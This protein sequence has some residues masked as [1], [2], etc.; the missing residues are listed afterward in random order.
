MEGVK[1]CNDF[2]R[3]GR[4]LSTEDSV[5]FPPPGDNGVG[6][7]GIA[8]PFP[9]RYLTDPPEPT[10]WL[11]GGLL[12]A[13]C[14][15][16]LAAAPKAGKT[17]LTIGIAIALAT[18][19]SILD[20]QPEARGRTLFYSP[21]SGWNAR[22][23]RLW[24]LCW[25]QGQDPRVI[26][27]DTPFIDA[28]LDLTL[29]A[30]IARLTALVEKEQPR[31][32]VIDPLVCAAT[33]IDENASH[34]VMTILSPLRDLCT[35]CPDL[36]LLVVHHTAKAAGERS[37]ALGIRGSSAIDAW[38]DTL[39]TL[40]RAEDDS[41]APRRIDVDH[42]DSPAPE[43]GGFRLAA[44]PAREEGHPELCWFRLDSCEP[45]ELA[46][47]R[48][49]QRGRPLESNKLE[50]VFHLVKQHSGKLTRKKGDAE[51]GW[52]DHKKF[53]RYFEEL[54]KQGRARLA[55]GG[56]MEVTP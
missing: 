2:V 13:G 28:R 53:N 46:R 18:G 36:S 11:V 1:D 38:R 22:T 10:R 41:T 43:P 4:R 48:G 52:N 25:G 45:P 56:V 42:R 19:R 32:L 20:W 7:A 8:E 34:E 5:P 49:R 39:I 35:N 3:V 23:Q 24:G 29:S 40:R 44:G 50:E 16:V 26:G 30:H 15:A 54:V 51:L 12:P 27:S 6:Q 37:R 31:L 14:C 47:G 17:W 21:E 33:G 9:V 55:P